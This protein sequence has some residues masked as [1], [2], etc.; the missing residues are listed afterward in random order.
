MPEQ[1]F[2]PL[3]AEAGQAA[4]LPLRFTRFFGRDAEI[5]R[6]VESLRPNPLMPTPHTRHIT[7]TGAGGAGKTRLAIEVAERLVEPFQGAVWFVPLADITDERLI[8]DTI[9]NSLR[10][11]RSPY[12][13][14]LEQVV[15]ALSKQPSLL[16]LDN[17][18][19]LVE[20]G[21]TLVQTL[22]A[23]LPTLTVLVT[24]RHLLGLSGE[25]E[26]VVPPLVT[27]N[28]GETAE[29]LSLYDSVQLFVDRAQTAMPHFQITNSNAPA[30]AELCQRLEGMPLAIEL[31]AAR[32]M[33]LTPGQMLKQLEQRFGFLVSRKHDATER[34][35][36]L[37]AAIDWSYRLLTPELQRFFT[38]LSVFRGGWTAEAAEAVCEEPLA[39]DYLA[40]LRE[41]SLALVE[42][43]GGEEMRFR[44]LESLREYAGQK[45]RES[46]E[47]AV[48]RSKHL[49]FHLALAEEAQPQLE[50]LE[51]TQ[52]LN[53]LETE[54]DNLRAA[55]DWNLSEVGSA[56]CLGLCG[57]LQQ[58]W[59]IRGNLS[60]GRAWCARILGMAGGQKRS[61]ERAKVLNGAGVLA[62][63]Q[64][65]HASA[66]A[67]LEES[68]SIKREIGDRLGMAV[69][70]NGLG[71]VAKSQGDYASAQAHY[72][73]SLTI[74]REVGDRNGIA[75]SLNNLG[76][77][78]KSQGDYASAST[79]Y[80]ESLVIFKEMGHRN[81]MAGP[82][83]NLG[84]IARC[85]G[86]Y[87]SARNHY[88]DSL[89]IKREIGNRW[90][91]AYSLEAFAALAANENKTKQAA[92]LWG[93]AEAL[94]EEI[95]SPLPPGEREPYDR[96]VAAA[97]QAANAETFVAAWRKD[98]LY[99]WNRPSP[100]RW[101]KGGTESSEAKRCARR[102][103][104]RLFLGPFLKRSTAAKLTG[105]H[106]NATRYLK[107][108]SSDTEILPY[109][110][111]A[112]L[113]YTRGPE[114]RKIL[115][116][117]PQVSGF[118]TEGLPQIGQIAA[119]IILRL[120]V[121]TIGP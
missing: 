74:F 57:A 73:A 89:V 32:A 77:V 97:R 88:E 118:R 62:R 115:R 29:Q 76:M 80:E 55:L 44:L 100:M 42:E 23:R 39:L 2:P 19:H 116:K 109:C 98:A 69:S 40:Q 46:G 120:R 64:G 110:H 30:V 107:A 79:Y 27:P 117:H 50:G 67:Y 82:L 114:D 15:E 119:Q 95:G 86:N 84:D 13:E 35:R 104:F 83:I 101:K 37:Q 61:Q 71:I 68:L 121:G 94:R 8:A 26:F 99:L 18:E 20:G 72:E 112:L 1:T 21:A 96:E 93:A 38:R 48:T 52:W 113:F 6:L 4:R 87:A 70:L 60:E 34:H 66:Q 12:R 49:A 17:F 11:E 22:L 7:L 108:S 45:L 81:G 103:R 41:C 16:V 53:R 90:G 91:I 14:P 102:V 47:E 54:H 58:F 75:M 3:S 63:M 85:Q 24:S 78:F 10:V 9:L 92:A 111:A 5:S 33:V 25:V 105:T 36:T 59:W 28:G 65:D 51:V 56:E 106:S 43:E 31:A